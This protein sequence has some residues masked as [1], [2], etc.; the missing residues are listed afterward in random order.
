MKKELMETLI[1]LALQ[2]DLGPH[3]VTTNALIPETA[4]GIAKVLAKEDFLL[5][6]I[7]VFSRVFSRLDSKTK[8][9]YFFRDGDSIK[10]GDIIA[11]V[12]GPLRALL[13]G[14]RTA[15]NFLQRLS[16]IATFCRM[17]VKKIEDYPVKILDTR[18]TTPGWRMLEKEA[19]RIG[20]GFNHRFGL[21]DGVLIKDNHIQAV[22]SITRAIT[23]ARAYAPLT[24][25]I[26]V[27]VNRLEQVEEALAAKAD[28]IM[29][30]NMSIEEMEV[31]VKKINGRALVEA[32]GG[33]TLK[34]VEAVAKT[35]VNFISLGALTSNVRSVDISMELEGKTDN[36]SY[37]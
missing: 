23:L 20:G 31:A 7:E 4:Y 24:L 15:L 10:S 17:I 32:S 35:G 8:V 18:K 26:E 14:E 29:L 36:A 16:G 21:F 12:N 22:G 11:E 13:S 28:I 37:H 25:K 19:I 3:D 30:D 5:A 6:G 34:N 27:E 33:I 9:T 2:E 1:D